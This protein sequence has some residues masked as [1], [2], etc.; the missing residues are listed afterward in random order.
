MQ[1]LSV[2]GVP[3]QYAWVV[4]D[5]EAA[6]QH[7]AQTVGVGP[8]FVSEVDSASYDGFLYRGEP[9]SL[10]MRVAWAQGAQGQIELIEVSSTA[11]NIYHD[12]IE[13]GQTGFHHVG[14]WSD[15]YVSDRA[16]LEADGF[17]VAQ[18]MSPSNICYFDTTAQLGSMVEVIERN[19]GIVGLF[20]LVAKAAEDWDGDRPLRPVAELMGG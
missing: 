6:A 15:D 2:P 8:F 4:A 19:D 11:P 7:W 5:M 20:A 14:I 18:D 12:V 13:P 9:G 1:K 17:V 16:A 3:F 10:Q